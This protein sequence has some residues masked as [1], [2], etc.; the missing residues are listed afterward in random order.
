[1][2]NALSNKSDTGHNHNISDLTG[3]ASV[4]RG[5][6]GYSSIVDTSYT[7]ARYRASSLHTSETNPSDSGIIAW[8]Y[9]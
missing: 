8:Q 2:N 3:T 4:E 5:G 1:M 6:T 7:T 9:G